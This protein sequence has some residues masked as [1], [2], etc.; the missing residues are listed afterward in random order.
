MFVSKGEHFFV[1]HGGHRQECMIFDQAGQAECAAQPPG[2]SNWAPE[3]MAHGAQSF[4]SP[5]NKSS[6]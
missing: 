6:G 5:Q 1:Y 4:C 3:P 2:K